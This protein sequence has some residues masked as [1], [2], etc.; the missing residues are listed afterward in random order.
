M[1]TL[2]ILYL[3]RSLNISASLFHAQSCLRKGGFY[4]VH[5][6]CEQGQLKTP[7]YLLGK[8]KRLVETAFLL[9]PGMER[10]RKNT[11][12]LAQKGICFTV[13][14]KEASEKLCQGHH[15]GVLKSM[16]GF[17]EG[18]SVHSHCS[19]I[20]KGK[21]EAAA[22]V[23]HKGSRIGQCPPTTK[24]YGLPKIDDPRLTS[25]TKRKREKLRNIR[26]TNHTVL[27]KE[28]MEYPFH[29]GSSSS[30]SR[31]SLLPSASIFLRQS[32]SN[33]NSTDHSGRQRQ[34][35]NS[36]NACQNTGL[37][38]YPRVILSHVLEKHS[39]LKNFD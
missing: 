28:K 33:L 39:L 27:G 22:V 16:Q 13:L 31:R 20:L 24:A 9:P 37:H 32:L 17:P 12:H 10:N 35:L 2:F 18:R 19:S 34:I 38:E 6:F 15:S 11:I 4:T 23:T 5:A 1:H 26:P 25:L 14:Y 3:K 8:E 7:A 36:P 21:G 29:S 30:S